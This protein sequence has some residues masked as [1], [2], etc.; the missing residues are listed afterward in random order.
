MP[1]WV[2]RVGIL[3]RVS[4]HRRGCGVELLA[5][6][7]VLWI[8][9]AIYRVRG[10]HKVRRV[11]VSLE[12]WAAWGCVGRW[13]ITL[14]FWA[15]H[16]KQGHSY[17]AQAAGRSSE[18]RRASFAGVSLLAVGSAWVNGWSELA[19]AAGAALAAGREDL[20]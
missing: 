7:G 14:I 17:V 16:A 12:N 6:L 9:P 13:A 10:I 18:R 3:V 8:R 19:A 5:M 2:H 4:R 15:M 1:V 20:D 11:W